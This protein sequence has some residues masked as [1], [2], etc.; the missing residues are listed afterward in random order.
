MTTLELLEYYADL[1]ILQYN[2]KPNAS[3][4]IETF[5]NPIIM[6]QTSTQTIE[7]SS[8]PDS[9]AFTL[10]YDDVA[11][12]SIAYNDNAAAIQTKLRAVTGLSSVTVTGS[13]ASG[14]TVTFTGVTPPALLLVEGTNTLQDGSDDVTITITETDLTLPLAVQNG[15]NL[16]GDDTAIGDQLDVIGKYAG[17]SRSGQ[18]FST[19][20]TLDDADFLQLIRAAIVQNSSGSSLYDIQA[21]IAE[22]FPAYFL[23]LLLPFAGQKLPGKPAAVIHYLFHIH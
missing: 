1:L 8:E 10:T 21:L 12:A 19:N 6:P 13:I 18:G 9:G 20:I 11:T 23:A 15:Y 4:T 22:F 5:A 2:G 3:G 7:F 14:L 16:T 17:V